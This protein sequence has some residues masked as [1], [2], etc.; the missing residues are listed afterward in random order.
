MVIFH[1]SSEK[2]EVGQRWRGI[3]GKKGRILAS[4]NSGFLA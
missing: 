4:S 3:S 1:L 2:L